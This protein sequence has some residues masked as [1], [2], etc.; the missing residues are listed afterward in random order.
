MKKF[1]KIDVWVSVVLISIFLFWIF[2]DIIRDEDWRMTILYSFFVVGGWHIISMIVHTVTRFYIGWEGVR[3]LY[4]IFSLV[5]LLTIPLGSVWI[6]A[7]AAPF[8][9]LF[10]TYMCYDETYVKMKRPLDILK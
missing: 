2:I 3:I 9:A 5:L 1:K 8:M 7:F 6:L 4:H 10:Y